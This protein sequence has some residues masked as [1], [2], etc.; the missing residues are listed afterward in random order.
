MAILKSSGLPVRTTPDMATCH[1]AGSVAA[2]APKLDALLFVRASAGASE[3]SC[4]GTPLAF[5]AS[6]TAPTGAALCA[7][8]QSGCSA[9]AVAAAVANTPPM[10]AV[11]AMNEQF[12]AVSATRASPAVPST[13]PV[14]AALPLART[15]SQASTAGPR[16]NTAPPQ[17]AP[18]GS[19]SA[20]PPVASSC[21]KLPDES[22]ATVFLIR[23]SSRTVQLVAATYTAPLWA[24]GAVYFSRQRMSPTKGRGRAARRSDWIGSDQIGSSG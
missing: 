17:N 14:P 22:A 6:S 13:P 21:A 4:A 8:T 11:F 9:S 12:A 18:S 2:T 10:L 16:A 7:Y 24:E 5:A 20:L 15:R 23:V 1:L 19:T 3:S